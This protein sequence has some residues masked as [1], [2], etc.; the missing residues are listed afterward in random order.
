MSI[1]RVPELGGKAVISLNV[2]LPAASR[3]APDQLGEGLRELYRRGEF[4][5]VA[6]IC[7]EQT[8]TAHRVVLAAKSDVFR[9]GLAGPK[10]EGAAKQEVR[11]ADVS[12]PEAVRF[13]LDHL[14]EAEGA[15]EEYDPKT[16]EVNKDVLRLAQHFHLPGLGERATQWLAKGLTTGN[17]VERLKLCEDFSLNLLK[18]KILEQLTCNRRALS[19]V[20]HSPQIMAYPR[21]MQALLQQAAAASDAEAAPK[22]KPRRG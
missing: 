11:L 17:V 12:N 9:Q 4:T 7:A 21:L 2:K 19:E 1:D 20:A 22:K 13:M 8:I 14:Y 15:P 5:D 3:A 18:E 10:D 16:Q 6:L